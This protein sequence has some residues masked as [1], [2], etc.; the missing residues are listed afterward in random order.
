[1]KSREAKPL[2]QDR[3]SGSKDVLS[4]A[5]LG[6]AGPGRRPSAGADPPVSPCP[7]LSVESGKVRGGLKGVRVGFILR[8]ST[9]WREVGFGN[10]PTFTL[11]MT[12][13]C[14]GT[15]AANLPEP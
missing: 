7:F 1:M 14:H 11:C 2:P 10:K 9:E 3:D 6:T 15:L 4:K 12:L 13:K 5:E 8:S